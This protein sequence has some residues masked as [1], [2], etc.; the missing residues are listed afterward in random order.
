MNDAL[1]NSINMAIGSS[2]SKKIKLVS[3]NPHLNGESIIKDCEFYY[4]Y[5]VEQEAK[6]DP[7]ES[8]D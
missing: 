4:D 6:F 3:N 8:S 7:Q 2:S 1:D 5:K